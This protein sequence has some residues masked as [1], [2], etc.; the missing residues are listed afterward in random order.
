MGIDPSDFSHGICAYM[1]EAAERRTDG[2]S[3]EWTPRALLQEG[4]DRITT[5]PS[6]KA[7]GSTACVAIAHSTGHIDIANLG[8]SGCYH[9][10]VNPGN[11]EKFLEIKNATR[12]MLHGFNTPYQLSLST[13]KMRGREKLFGPTQIENFPGE[14]AITRWELQHGDVL[15]IYTDGFSDNLNPS[16]ILKTIQG[17]LLA[18]GFW[19]GIPGEA[20][21]KAELEKH[22]PGC[23]PTIKQI[24]QGQSTGKPQLDSVEYG[25]TFES[26]D[27]K[28]KGR[29]GI[30]AQSA[31]ALA[32]VRY[33]KTLAHATRVSTPFGENAMKFHPNVT[34]DSGKPDDTCVIA[35][36]VEEEG[37]CA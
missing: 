11:T 34:M 17:A 19:K 31:L 22:T 7:G 10:R 36:L 25:E 23:V 30:S 2:K 1:A 6:V 12:P 18:K 4:F 21:V 9:S 14:A 28:T 15:L 5:D 37:R 13:A 24:V 32:A 33:A 26:I 35:V 27:Q 16:S 8:D 3:T 20:E 29:E